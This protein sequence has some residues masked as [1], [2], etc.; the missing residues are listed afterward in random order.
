MKLSTAFSSLVSG[1]LLLAPVT[2]QASALEL[3]LQTTNDPISGN[4][5][6]ADDLYTAEVGL[7]L[8]FSDQ[9]WAFGERMFTDRE[10]SLRFDETFLDVTRELPTWLNWQPEVSLGV[11]HVGHG[12]LGEKVQNEIHRWVG[13]RRVELPYIPNSHWFATG[14]LRLGRVLRGGPHAVWMAEVV[15]YAAPGFQESLRAQLLGDLRLGGGLSLRAG[16]GART[17]RVESSLLEGRVKE[18]G[19]TWEIGI[20]WR[21]VL[22]RYSFND[23]GTETQHVALVVKA[24]S[25]PS[26]IGESP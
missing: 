26:L 24:G 20:S 8:S 25:T 7:G 10:R 9:R 17:A 2:L 22:L 15:A 13:S 11:L 1:L 3:S 6:H 12:L 5:E 19:A 23:H 18:L 4:D 21:D 14:R 16:V